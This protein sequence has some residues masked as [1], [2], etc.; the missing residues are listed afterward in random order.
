MAKSTQN[1]CCDVLAIE[2]VRTMAKSI[3]NGC[4]NVL[5]TEKARDNGQIHPKSLLQYV[6][7]FRMVGTEWPYPS[8][9]VVTM[10]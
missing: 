8:R 10:S 7:V 2:K 6:I 5:A 4:D 3:Q 9:M 1:G